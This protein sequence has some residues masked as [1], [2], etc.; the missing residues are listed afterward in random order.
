MAKELVQDPLISGQFLPLWPQLG[1]E[2]PQSN[3]GLV[4]DDVV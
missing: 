3:Q 4:P 2:P 1:I